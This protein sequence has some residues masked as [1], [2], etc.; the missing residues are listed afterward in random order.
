MHL[1]GFDRRGAAA[2]LHSATAT[3]IS[4]SG[5]FRS[6]DDFAVI[7]L[8]KRDNIF[9]HHS[10]RW[11]EDGDLSGMTLSFD[12]SAGEAVAPLDSTFFE[13]IPNRSLSFIR[14]NGTSG[15]VPL[16]DYASLQSGDFD[17]ASGTFHFAESGGG[18]KRYDRIILWYLN[19]AFEYSPLYSAF[20]EFAFFN[21]A[22]AGAE[23]SITTPTA[24]YNYTQLAADGS[25]DVANALVALVNAGAGDPDVVA[26]IGSAAHIVRLDPLHEGLPVVVSAM[27]GGGMG[28][29]SATLE[30]VQLSTFP[31][32]IAES[33]NTFDWTVPNPSLALIAEASGTDLS[34]K[35]AR[36]GTCDVDEDS[37][38]VTWTSGHKFQGL[39]AG[40]VMYVGGQAN[41]VARVVSNTSL[42]LT[43]IVVAEELSGLRFLTERGG[44]DGNFL[45]LRRQSLRP[46]S[47]T[48]DV[49]AGVVAHVSGDLFTGLTPDRYIR[50]NNV[51]FVIAS[52]DTP[53]Q[54]TL[55]TVTGSATGVAYSA[56]IEDNDEV[57]TSEESLQ[58]EGGSSTVTWRVSLDFSNTLV[59]TAGDGTPQPIDDLFEAWLTVAPALADAADFVD[60]EFNL[61]ISNMS[62][63]DTESK[64][65][66]KV[67]GPGSIRI[68]SRQ[69]GVAYEGA[70]WVEKQGFY[71]QGFARETGGWG[72]RVTVRYCCQA[73]HDHYV[74]TEIRDGGASATVTLDGD[75]PTTLNTGMS[76]DPPIVAIRKVRSGVPADVHELVL[77]CDGN[78]LFTFDHIEAA[79][80]SNVHDPEETLS[81]VSM[82]TDWD[83]DATYKLPAA[84]LLWQLDRSGFHGDL[85]HFVG[86]FF[87]YNRRRRP[88][89]GLRNQAT[90]TFG[91]YWRAGE[92]VV[93]N[94]GDILVRKSIF[95]GDN[96]RS[97]AAHVEAFINTT[98]VG[99]FA[100]HSGAEVTIKNRAN[101]YGF[102]LSVQSNDSLAGTASISG[103]LDKGSEGIWEID[104]AADP[105]LNHAARQ[106]HQDFFNQLDSRGRTATVAYNL[107]A[108]NPPETSADHWAARYCSGRQVLTDVGFG[109]EG[110]AKI[111]DVSNSAPILVRADNHGY[112]TGDRVVVS[113]VS[114]T[115]ANGAFLITVVN[116]DRFE[117][118]GTDG[119]SDAPFTFDNAAVIR[120]LRTTHLAPN[121]VVTDFQKRIYTETADMMAAAGLPVKLQFGEFLWWFFSETSRTI[122]AVSAG[123]PIRVTTAQP[124]GFSSGDTVIVAGVVSPANASGTHAITVIDATS[125]DLD[126][127]DGV[128]QAVSLAADARVAGGSMAFYDAETAD[129]AVTALG[130]PLARFTCQDS[131]PA[132][133]ASADADF[134]RDRLAAHLDAIVA[135][136][137]TSHP[138]AV[139]ELL[140]PF[141][142]LHPVTYH[143]AQRP[144]PQGGRLNHH[145]STPENW[146]TPADADRRL[147]IE[148]LSWGAFYRHGNRAAEAMRLW[149]GAEGFSWPQ[150][151]VSYLIPWF[152]GGAPWQREYLEA[153]RVGPGEIH[154]WALDHYRLLEWRALPRPVRESRFFGK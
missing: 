52:V 53:T 64:R 56:T 114:G 2:A 147:K 143:A 32:K 45:R 21:A 128:G 126:G 8:F 89:T 36:F 75:A 150:R 80:P 122:T 82:A 1:R 39:A 152:N 35:A 70:A 111:R 20:G 85:N 19:L 40:A 101:L 142:V 15:T 104:D 43:D 42:V 31:K 92:S 25:G 124:H 38:T 59:Q 118:D 123:A 72:D 148:A 130:R 116:E 4:C 74:G 28:G 83:T 16:F 146:K 47:G 153:R 63:V 12:Y 132:V 81:D 110:E 135:H 50:I 30:Y 61:Q 26:S 27:D 55:A 5:V 67:A 6:A 105:L 76:I 10:V 139:F 154:F 66:L 60:S 54:I 149:Q 48:V 137:R 23:H 91:G 115:T 103:S 88:G 108:Y 33:I 112:S 120:T 13:S 117:L 96:P 140:Y 136:V 129:A 131:D 119:T 79:I 107:E 57:T 73:T 97:I 51:D 144:Y 14:N 49:D 94:I 37:V 65:P 90:V 24:V 133:N 46:R 78:G 18:F 3:S 113:G 7:V 44:C 93:L 58:L 145:V 29:G 71:D 95:A 121:P 69:P 125:F 109:S 98:F 138:T 62:V 41:T 106:W 100:E 99:V 68:H 141:D 102:S 77:T 87:Q 134:L 127:T 11:L 151:Q 86:N 22:G 34:I 9:E 84:R 17:V